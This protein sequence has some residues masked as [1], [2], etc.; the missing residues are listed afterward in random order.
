MSYKKSSFCTYCYKLRNLLYV[1][2]RE[3]CQA[4]N[5]LY[6]LIFCVYFCIFKY[7]QYTKA[8][9]QVLFVG[10]N[11][12]M[13]MAWRLIIA[14]PHLICTDDFSL[15]LKA[16]VNWFWQQICWTVVSLNWPLGQSTMPVQSISYHDHLFV[17]SFT[18]LAPYAGSVYRYSCL[19]VIILIWP[20]V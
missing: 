17:C 16:I 20:F 9:W 14:G 6:L 13:L 19:P 8:R 15:A 12:N 7:Q 2:C 11:G 10:F 3:D 18:E 5:R 4:V 1:D